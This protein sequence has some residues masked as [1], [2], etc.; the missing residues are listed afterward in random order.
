[1]KCK[2]KETFNIRP[3]VLEEKIVMY[4]KKNAYRITE[5]GLG[6]I[7][8]TEDEYSE[9]RI[10]RSDFHT[11]MGEGKFVFSYSA[12]DET[13]VELIYLT[14]VTFFAVLVMLQ[15]AF[16]IYANDFIMPIVMSLFLILPILFRIFYLNQHVFVEIVE[17]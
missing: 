4:L 10:A 8:F 7:I 11:R 15:C 6:Y 2:I 9:R 1:M 16:G 12:C 5:K 17:C 13:N 3:D 14:S